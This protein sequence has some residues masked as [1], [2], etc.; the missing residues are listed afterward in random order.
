MQRKVFLGMRAL[1]MMPGKS[2]ALNIRTGLDHSSR[3]NLSLTGCSSAEPASVLIQQ[4]KIQFSIL[5]LQPVKILSHLPVVGLVSNKS[6][7]KYNC[8]RS[9]V[10]Y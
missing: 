2:P 9:I 7:G 10:H 3:L 8:S 6:T 4:H 1:G 5:Y